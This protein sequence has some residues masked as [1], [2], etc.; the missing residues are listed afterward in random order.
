MIAT[1]TMELTIEPNQYKPVCNIIQDL[2]LDLEYDDTVNIMD[3]NTINSMTFLGKGSFGKVYENTNGSPNKVIKLSNILKKLNYYLNSD[4]ISESMTDNFIKE[5]RN[6]QKQITNFSELKQKFPANITQIYDTKCALIENEPFPI[7]MI[8]MEKINGIVLQHFLKTCNDKQFKHVVILLLQIFLYAN[9][10]GYF[11][12]DINMHNIMVCNM[13][14]PVLIDYSFSKKIN[15]IGVYPI[16]CYILL[17]DIKNV[18]K[19]INIQNNPWFFDIF[20]LFNKLNIK[21]SI[22]ETNFIEKV[23]THSGLFTKED[24]EKL[25]LV[26]T[27]DIELIKKIIYVD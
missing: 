23:L 26:E 9:L 16:E 10:N 3:E 7:N 20:E 6:E 15:K 1:L 18:V 2:I 4:K 27:D 21:Y 25:P 8:I 14:T 22:Y 19:N 17:N 5:F 12:N 24:Y 13:I 11:H